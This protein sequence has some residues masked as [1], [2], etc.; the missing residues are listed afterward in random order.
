MARTRNRPAA[1]EDDRL[2]V[3]EVLAEEPEDVIERGHAVGEG[4]L[5]R[6][7]ADIVITAIIGGAEVSL[8][9]LA[10][11]VVIGALLGAAPHAGLYAALALAGA[12]FPIGF[13]F[14]ILHWRSSCQPSSPA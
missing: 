13:V 12:V 6:S 11:A 10:A 3:D 8:G 7:T 14:V 9:G 1:G 2:P 5:A 4:R